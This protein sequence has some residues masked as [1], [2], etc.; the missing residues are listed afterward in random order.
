M[1]DWFKKGW[2]DAYYKRGVEPKV[3]RTPKIR[4]DYHLGYN[5]AKAKLEEEA[6]RKRD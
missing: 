2:N 1:F 6:A 5:A 4:R 3:P